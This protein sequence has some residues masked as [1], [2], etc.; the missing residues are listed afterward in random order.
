[1]KIPHSE[2]YW[3]SSL[4]HIYMYFMHPESVKIPDF[5]SF[6][7]LKKA[8]ETALY[9]SPISSISRRETS[10]C[11]CIL[12]NRRIDISTHKKNVFDNKKKPIG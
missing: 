12:S 4:Q 5:S 7:K 2:Y 9:I 3:Y 1:M 8:Y 10:R 6:Q 11:Q